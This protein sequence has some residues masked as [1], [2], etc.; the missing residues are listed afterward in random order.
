MLRGPDRL[1]A[2]RWTPVHQPFSSAKG[3]PK[4]ANAPE[5]LAPEEIWG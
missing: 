3:E 4:V 5:P 1:A 2:L